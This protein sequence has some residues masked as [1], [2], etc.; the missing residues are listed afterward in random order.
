MEK[1][2]KIF[3]NRILVFLL[4]T[5]LALSFTLAQESEQDLSQEKIDKAYQCLEDKVSDKCSSLTLEEQIFSLLALEHKSSINNECI[6][7]ILS[8]SQNNGEC[9]PKGNCNVKQTSQV[10]LALNEAGE[11][12]EKAETWIFSQN[13]TP[14]DLIWYLE[15]ETP[16]GES[17][18]RI[19]YS[20]R[21]Y[22]IQINEDK[23][24]SSGAGSCLDLS[25]GNYWLKVSPNCLNN[26]YAISCNNG[27]LTTLL[28]QK[29]NG[30]TI[31][32][33]SEVNSASGNGSTI[34]KIDTKCFSQGTRCNYEGTL[35]ASFV[36]D[37]NYNTN[38]YI[39]YLTAFSDDNKPYFPDTFLYFLTNFDDYLTNILSKQKLDKY[40]EESN[41]KLYD[42]SLALLVLQ[43]TEA[44]QISNAKNYL[45]SI[46]NENGCW[47]NNIRNTGF[48]L[49]SAFPKTSPI[50]GDI[51]EVFCEDSDGYCLSSE[52]CEDAGG[53]DLG[54]EL[55]CPSVTRICC[56]QPPLEE[57]C[58]EKGGLICDLNEECSIGTTTSSD[59]NSCCLGACQIRQQPE[60][61]ECEDF[62]GICQ[63]SCD[64]NEES[65][66]Y[67]CTIRSEFCCVKKITTQKTS[68][69]W[70]WILLILIVLVIIGI[71]FRNKFREWIFR[72]KS[73]G[74]RP[75]PPTNYRPQFPPSRPMQRPIQRRILPPQ[76]LAQRQIK[77]P[78]ALEKEFNETL[79]KL[80]DIGK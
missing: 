26:E 59:T 62:G 48:I 41:D 77:K 14:E 35:W 58:S 44:E 50:E 5:I 49:Y 12:T 74:S 15:I 64:E 57:T 55:K 1:K 19:S 51:T 2:G 9:W 56:S 10:I 63:T 37:N 11:D 20:G 30:E 32:V 36:L 65:K 16:V 75:S 24:L 78:S 25:T 80:K 29:R 27:F 8:N 17:S 79:G 45:L 60:I 33:S 67:E 39:P 72:M 52:S 68:K 70:I 18:C 21:D 4:F 61:S 13:R 73:G 69:L 28:Y 43:N 46:Q 22:L 53:I 23:T 54:A 38:D 7:A 3:E 31:Y 66:T 76:H 6:D 42:T 40:W 34:E 47:N 71:I